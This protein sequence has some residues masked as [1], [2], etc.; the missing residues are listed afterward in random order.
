[1]LGYAAAD[2]MNKISPADISDPKELIARAKS[3]SA[4]VGTTVAPGFEALV[5]KASHGTERHQ[6]VRRQRA[7]A[8][9]GR[10]C[11]WAC[12]RGAPGRAIV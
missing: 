5:F 10:C 8:G 1:M 3:L 7:V 6:P 12:R 9:R 4:E 2:V 11:L